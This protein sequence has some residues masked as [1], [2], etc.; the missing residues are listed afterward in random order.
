VGKLIISAIII[1]TL[2]LVGGVMY[3]AQKNSQN[4]T[5]EADVNVGVVEKPN[6][7]EQSRIIDST[8][9]WKA[10]RNEEYGFEI[11]YPADWLFNKENTS[12]YGPADF[13]EII[14]APMYKDSIP[15]RKSWIDVTIIP[16]SNATGRPTF[17][18]CMQILIVEG[19]KFCKFKEYF[20]DHIIITAEAERH[21][22][23][24]TFRLVAEIKNYSY[25]EQIFNSIISSIRF[26]R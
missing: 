16:A 12:S 23:F 20:E 10:Y 18:K 14:Y 26:T 8:V 25:E 9:G 22:I 15:I 11:R 6:N 21:G 17:L 1:P 24:F 4:Q 3:V 13:F 5:K 19:T 7:Q 2:I